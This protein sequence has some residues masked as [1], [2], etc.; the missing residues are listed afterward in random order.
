MGLRYLPWEGLDD[1]TLRSWGNTTYLIRD[2]EGNVVHEGLYAGWGESPS[3]ILQ[4]RRRAMLDEEH[5]I[6]FDAWV[7]APGSWATIEIVGAVYD[8]EGII[9]E[10]AAER[11]A[12]EEQEEAIR[13]ATTA[14]QLGVAPTVGRFTPRATR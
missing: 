14:S 7:L 12:R 13:A 6:A 3:G 9:E 5:T 2:A 8:L 1:D 4:L 11:A 10:E